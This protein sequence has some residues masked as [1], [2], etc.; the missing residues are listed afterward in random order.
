MTNLLL[1]IENEAVFIDLSRV[2]E[3]LPLDT[4]IIYTAPVVKIHT[5]GSL[6][7]VFG[8]LRIYA[9]IISDLKDFFLCDLFQSSPILILFMILYLQ[10]FR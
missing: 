7:S 8:P 3:Y 1:V 4:C 2:S 6:G 9:Q 10:K 5:R